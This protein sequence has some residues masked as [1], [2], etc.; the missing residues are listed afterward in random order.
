MNSKKIVFTSL[1]VVT[2]MISFAALT[3]S[4]FD[5]KAFARVC[6][7]FTSTSNRVAPM[8]A[9]SINN[10]GGT[11]GITSFTNSSNWAL[12][13][14]VEPPIM[15]D[16]GEFVCAICFDNAQYTL[17]QAINIAWNTYSS[18]NPK[19]FIHGEDVDP[20][21]SRIVRIYLKSVSSIFNTP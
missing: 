8:Q 20:S 21:A 15:C 6:Y 4:S 16:D 7:E 12:L 13:G 10:I 17:Q 5:K 14:D 11:T 2:A 18:R 3:S 19:T 1:F 9:D